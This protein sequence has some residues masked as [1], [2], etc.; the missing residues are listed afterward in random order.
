M[1]GAASAEAVALADF[2]L[3]ALR[4]GRRKLLLGAALALSLALGGAAWMMRDAPG[5][6]A[7]APPAPAVRVDRF[8]VPLPPG[9]LLRLGVASTGRR[10]LCFAVSDDGRRIASWDADARVL[11]WWDVGTGAEL[12]LAAPQAAQVVAMA[13]SPTGDLLATADV[14]RV[15]AQWDPATGKHVRRCE[16]ADADVL[17]LAFASDG[18]TLAASG[19][20]RRVHFWGVDTGH[21]RDPW[22][23]GG[24][25]LTSLSFA[26]RGGPVAVGGDDGCVHLHDPATGVVVRSFSDHP[27]AITCVAFAPDGRLLAV[28]CADGSSRLW[29]VGTGRQRGGWH[30][31]EA[32]VC[33]F[34]FAPY[35]TTLTS[36]GHDQT[37]CRRDVA[38][39]KELA[40]DKIPPAMGC[41]VPPVLVPN[42]PVP[43]V[44]TGIE[45]EL[46]LAVGNFERHTGTLLGGRAG[47]VRALVFAPDGKSLAAMDEDHALWVWDLE[48]GA[49]RCRVGAFRRTWGRDGYAPPGQTLA[50]APDGRVLAEAGGG[51][52]GNPTVAAEDQDDGVRLWTVGRTELALNARLGRPRFGF[53]SVAISVDGDALAAG[54]H[55]GTLTVWDFAQRR[56]RWSGQRPGGPVHFVAFSPDGKWLVDN[57]LTLWDA[58]TGKRQGRFPG[59][60]G[61]V[62]AGVFTPDGR[63]IATAAADGSLCLWAVATRTLARRIV[64]HRGGAL[65]VAVSADGRMLASSGHDGAVALWDAATGRERHRFAGHV[66]PVSAVAFAPDG[67]SLASAGWDGTILV[68]DVTN[69]SGR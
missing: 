1:A 28:G 26:P 61:Q 67:R 45:N 46:V 13:F 8:G 58:S 31:H 63:T 69:E 30:D 43:C 42:R 64:A 14:N 56:Q 49:Q 36:A 48:V 10:G 57:S 44:V 60:Q 4:A 55:D 33:S 50:F 51:A 37:I 2:A 29:D 25:P 19:A 22:P 40:R 24:A 12:P 15:V 18:R 6:A 54:S 66:G 27:A 34:A 35:G 68:W 20:D 62:A 5:P 32:A 9:A 52:E 7:S 16:A 11:R 53:L 21:R 41:D 47:R 65:G 23:K 38:D 3:A 39:G 59:G 17:R